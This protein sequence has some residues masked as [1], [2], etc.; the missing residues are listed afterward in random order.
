MKTVVVNKEKVWEVFSNSNRL[1]WKCNPVWVGTINFQ[2]KG[3]FH[4]LVFFETRF[5]TDQNYRVIPHATFRSSHFRKRR[6]HIYIL[7]KSCTS[8]RL[9]LLHVSPLSFHLLLEMIRFRS[10]TLGSVVLYG[11]V[12]EFE[13]VKFDDSQE[14]WLPKL[15]DYT[16]GISLYLFLYLNESRMNPFEDYGDG[17]NRFTILLL[18]LFFCV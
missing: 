5:P 4:V 11:L 14:A 18:L 12:L 7:I 17:W 2:V 13:S 15:P 8:N 1:N 6:S 3:S 16:I 10:N 9:P